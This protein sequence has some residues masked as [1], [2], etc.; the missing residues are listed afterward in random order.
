MKIAVLAKNIDD[1]ENYLTENFINCKRIEIP[2]QA[3]DNKGNV[4]KCVISERN[5]YGCRV[6][7]IVETLDFIRCCSSNE[8]RYYKN[9]VSATEKHMQ[10]KQYTIYNKGEN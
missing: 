10:R 7:K 5:L 1:F 9:L 6:D 4:Y 8:G 2:R 3:E